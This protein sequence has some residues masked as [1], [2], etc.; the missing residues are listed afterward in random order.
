[1]NPTGS[2]ASSATNLPFSTTSPTVTPQAQEW[3]VQSLHSDA[4]A[5]AQSPSSLTP[6]TSVEYLRDLR[7]ESLLLL[8]SGKF[9]RGE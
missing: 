3:D 9:M 5:G 2:L 7:N 4:V 1:M 6:G 8:T